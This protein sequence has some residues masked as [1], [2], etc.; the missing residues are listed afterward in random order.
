[1]HPRNNESFKS[2]AELATPVK[3]VLHTVIA[4]WAQDM[5]PDAQQQ[6]SNKLLFQAHFQS[7][8]SNKSYSL[9]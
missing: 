7:F 1:M 3:P 9:L 5:G 4:S 8:F 6:S 2:N